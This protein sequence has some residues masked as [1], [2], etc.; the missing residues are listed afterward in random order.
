MG[1]GGGIPTC[2]QEPQIPEEEGE[3]ALTGLNSNESALDQ[4][5]VSGS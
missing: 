3:S 1:E 4:N 2:P 5:P